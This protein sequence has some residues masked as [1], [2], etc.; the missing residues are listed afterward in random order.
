M[1]TTKSVSLSLELHYLVIIVNIVHV[2][3][4][5]RLEVLLRVHEGPV[6]ADHDPPGGGGVA[7]VEDTDGLILLFLTN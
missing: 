4:K 2:L 5:L 1:L 3:F 6:V 7:G